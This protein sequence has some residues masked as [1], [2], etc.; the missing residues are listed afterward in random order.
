MTALL[1][2]VAFTTFAAWLLYAW[3]DDMTVVKLFT[4]W[5]VLSVATYAAWHPW[6]TPTPSDDPKVLR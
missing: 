4:I 6:R 2:A 1:V 3:L 5:A